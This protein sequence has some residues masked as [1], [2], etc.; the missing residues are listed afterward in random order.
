MSCFAIVAL[1][2]EG[3]ELTRLLPAKSERHDR[4]RQE[5]RLEFHIVNIV[6]APA[7]RQ[8]GGGV[9]HRPVNLRDAWQQGL[10]GKVA[11]KPE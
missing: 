10:N 3:D 4:P 11:A 8:Q 5:W 2:A 7:G 6:K 9:M 1:I